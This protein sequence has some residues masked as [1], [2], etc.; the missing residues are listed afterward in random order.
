M[1]ILEKQLLERL[2]LKRIQLQ[3]HETGLLH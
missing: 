2:I 3:C 1:E